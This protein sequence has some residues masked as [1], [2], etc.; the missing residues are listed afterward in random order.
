MFLVRDEIARRALESA[1]VHIVVLTSRQAMSAADVALL[2][3]LQG[4][5]KDRIAVFINRI[6]ELGTLHAMYRQLFS[7]SETA[8]AAIFRP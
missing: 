7:M 4:L 8:C 2:R 3:I 1:H 6:D 5:R